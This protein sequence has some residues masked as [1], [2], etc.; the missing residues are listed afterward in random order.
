MV[1]VRPCAS[2]MSDCPLLQEESSHDVPKV[3]G[4][5]RKRTLQRTRATARH[6][7]WLTTCVQAATSHHS[8]IPLQSLLCDIRMLKKE[9]AAL[10]RL[11]QPK[12]PY[13]DTDATVVN[14]EVRHAAFAEQS[15]SSKWEPLPV[16]L[17]PVIE[18]S[19][20]EP[21][22]SPATF[23]GLTVI[24]KNTALT[25]LSP[26]GP[27]LMETEHSAPHYAVADKVEHMPPDM[28]AKVSAMKREIDDEVQK[29][30]KQRASK[31]RFQRP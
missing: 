17:K 11:V 28:E 4:A 30:L 20:G 14:T 5:A 16:A 23:G 19:T 29:R 1:N 26:A 8:G 12:V 10:K 31:N 15:L 18:A 22:H 25:E 27:S 6:V 2:V 21:A 7:S 3:A 13:T 9:I 24:V